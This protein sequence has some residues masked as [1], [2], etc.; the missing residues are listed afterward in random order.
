MLPLHA[1]RLP[2]GN[3]T[4]CAGNACGGRPTMKSAGYGIGPAAPGLAA[5]DDILAALGQ[6][7]MSI[8]V[9][10]VLAALRLASRSGKAS[11]TTVNIKKAVFK[12][13]RFH[14]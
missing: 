5:I 1:G 10:A 2:F 3:C 6:A 4:R 8:A 7:V 9:V 13:S 14:G 12:R 11:G